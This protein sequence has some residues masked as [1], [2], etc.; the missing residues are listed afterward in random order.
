MQLVSRK[1]G[2]EYMTKNM[3]QPTAVQEYKVLLE[4]LRGRFNVLSTSIF[5]LEENISNADHKTNKYIKQIHREIK[6][7]RELML[8]YPEEGLSDG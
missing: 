1:L 4:N 6:R 8:E 5:L 2:F 7:I 3:E